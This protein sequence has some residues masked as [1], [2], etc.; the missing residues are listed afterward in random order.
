MSNVRVLS[1]E[2]TGTDFE[3]EDK[4]I[5]IKIGD[6]VKLHLSN[7][8]IEGKIAE[9]N[10]EEI[11]IVLSH[12]KNVNVPFEYIYGIEKTDTEHSTH[13][14]KDDI[15]NL[16]NQFNKCISGLVPEEYKAGYLEALEH[17]IDK[18]K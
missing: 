17:I 12:G 7:D 13:C 15:E 6:M 16:R 8:M 3:F 10:S 9:L 4:V 18:C 1:V 14:R 11:E 2:F 5:Q